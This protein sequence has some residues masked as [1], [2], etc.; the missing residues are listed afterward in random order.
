MDKIQIKVL[1]VEDNPVDIV[2]LRETLG[3][4]A[5]NSFELTA[6]ERLQA[7]AETLS[8]NN[9]DVILLDLGLPDSQGLETFTHL[10][11]FARE[12]P[13]IILSGLTDESLA[14][15]AVHHGAQDYLVK[16]TTG[17]VSAARAIRYAIERQKAQAAV[18]ASEERFR[19]MIENGLDD[20]SLLDANGTLLWESPSVIRSLGYPVDTFV[21]KNIFEIVHPEDQGWTG[22]LYAKVLQAPGSREAGIFRLRHADGSW[23]WIEAIVTNM[24]NNPSVQAVV[25]NYR[26]ITE[27]KQAEETVR[28]LARFPEENPSPILRVEKEGRILYANSAAREQW[29]AGWELSVNDQ[30]P[31]EWRARA[32]DVF[33]TN[34][35]GSSDISIQERIYEITIAPFQESGYVNI[36]GRDITERKRA[37]AALRS[38]ETRYRG[39]FDGVQ[40]AIFVEDLDGNILDVNRRA[41]EIFG[42]THAE[43]IAKHVKDIV[44]AEEHMIRLWED[45]N[46]SLE[47]SYETVNVRA[48]GEQFP[49]EIRGGFYEF[50]DRKLFLVVLRDITERKQGEEK[51]RKSE[52]RHRTLVN[53]IPDMMFRITRAGV[54]LD[55]NGPNSQPY[56]APE[57]FLGKKITE[58]MPPAI[59]AQC[60][61]ALAASFEVGPQT[62]EYQLSMGGRNVSYEARAVSNP[63][64]D[65]A[66]F[67]VRDITERKQMEAS[68]RA[69]EERYR[70]LVENM[71]DII[72]E[73]DAQGKLCYI[74]PNYETE[75]GYCIADELG[76]LAFT[77]VHPDD[78][79]LFLQ[80]AKKVMGP[81][82][83][84]SMVYRVQNKSGKWRWLETS[85]KPYQTADGSFHI[86][87]VARDI[88]ERKQAEVELK[89][90]TDDLKLINTINN[91]VVQGVSLHAIMD[92]LAKGL[93]QVFDIEGTSVYLLDPDGKSLAMQ[94][95]IISPELTRSIEKV[96]GSTVPLIHIPIQ[97]GGYFEKFI[98][99]GRGTIM[100]DPDATQQWMAEF[101]ETSFLPSVARNAV[102]KLIPQI[103]K[104]MHIQSTL[105]AP[106]IS[107]GQTIGMLDASSVTRLF[108]NEDL[109]RIENICGQLTAAIQRQQ[110]NASIERSEAFLN[111][112]QNALSA[113]LAILD[114]KGTIVRV[115]A[116]WRKFGEQNGLKNPNACVGVNYLE[117]CDK[118][119]G[120]YAEEA[121]ATADAIRA[122]LTGHRK[123]MLLEYPCHG[124]QEQRWFTLR[125]T[126]FEDGEHAWVVLAHENITERKLAEQQTLETE[127]RFRAL[128]ERAPDGI[129]LVSG[130]G[131]YKYASPTALRLFDYTPEEIFAASPNAS[132]H[133]DDL[134]AVLGSLQDLIE[135]PS[136][137]ATL[138]YR[139]RHKDGTWRWLE[140][141]FTNMLAEPGVEAIV[142]NFRDITDR[143]QAEEAT[144]ETSEQF[145]TLFEASPEA[146]MLVDPNNS[147]WTIMDCN[148]TGC[149]MNGYTH[150]ELIGQS[151]DILNP[152][153]GDPA[154]RMDY[155]ARIRTAGILR[156]EASHRRKDGTVFPIEVATSLIRLGGREVI[157]GI[158]RDITER[159][160]AEEALHKSEALYRQAIE[161][162]GAVP[163]YESYYDNGQ[164]IKYDFIG[165]G[166]RQITGY[167]PEEFNAQVWDSLVEEA[168]LVDDLQGY[169]ID[170]GI[171]R[172]RAGENPIWK[173]E[174]RIR[175]RAGNLHWVFEAAVEL[176]DASG[177]SHGSIGT[178]QDITARKQAE[179]SLRESEQRYRA[180]FEDMPV[181]IWEEDFSEVKKYSDSLK[182]QGIT[183]FR[184]YFEANPE[185]A[186]ECAPKV[187]ILNANRAAVE[188]FH[189][190][191]KAELLSDTEQELSQGEKA[192]FV[193][194]VTN[195]AEG[196]T[197]NQ[198]EGA[199]E[200]YTGV[201][202]EINLNWSVVPGYEKDY[203]RIIVTTVDITE[204]KRAEREL[205]SSHSL[206]TATF[207]STADGIL[208]VGEKGEIISFNRR[209]LEL[210]HIPHE[211]AE[212][213]VDRPLLEF[214][215]SQL[216]DPA[217]F[218][219]KVEELYHAP[220]ETSIDE[221]EFLDGRVFERYSQPQRLGNTIIGRVWSFR[222]IT[223][224]KRAYE[225]VRESEARFASIF[226]ANP[227]RVSIT[228]FADGRFLDVNE[229]FLNSTGLNREEVIGRTSLEF[230]DWVDPQERIRLRTLLQEQGRVQHFET[231]LR[232]K[233]GEV[234]DV[235]ISAELVELFGQ[236]CILSV[237]LDI[238]DRKQ[239]EQ[240]LF[241]A[242][243]RFTQL[244]DNIQEVFWITDAITGEDLYISPAGEKIWGHSLADLMQIPDIFINTI[245]PEDRPMVL[246][247]I[248]GQKKGIATEIEYRIV[249]P[250][251]SIHW[252]WDRAFPI[253]DE[254]GN[255]LRVAGIAVDITERKQVDDALRARD[256]LLQDVQK[257]ARLGHYQLDIPSG[258]WES[259]DVLNDVLGIDNDYLKDMNGWVGLIHP[260][261][262]A[263]MLVY[264]NTEV[265]EEHKPFDRE[266]QMVRKDNGQIRWVHGLGQL[267]FDNTGNPV[268]M[269]GTIQ[270]ITERKQIEAETRRHLAELEA[271]YE[272]GLA[273]GR[274]LEPREIGERIIATFAR[275]LSWHHV[276]IRLIE[277]ESLE[278]ELIAFN[279][280]GMND[281]ANQDAQRNLNTLISKV[282]Q[283]LSGWVAQTGQP[284]RTGNVNAQPHYIATYREINSGLYMPLKI[285]ERCIG[286][287]SV[288]SHEPDAFSEQDERLL[289]TLASQAANAFENARLYEVVQQEL[290]ERTR[291]EIALRTSETHYRELTDSITDVF[292]EMDQNLCYTHWNKASEKL[293][294]IPEVSALGRSMHEVMGVSEEQTRIEKIYESV[295][296]SQH[297]T[298]FETHLSFNNQISAHE[299]TAYP[300]TRGVAV[301]AKDVSER[302]RSEII[303]QKRFELMEYAARHTLLETMQR[304]VDEV[305]DLTGSHIGFF[306]ILAA[307]QTTPGLQIW[308]TKTL[309][310]FNIPVSEGE[311]Q[312]VEQAGVWAEA[313]RQRRAIIH[314]DYE[315]MPNKKGLPTGHA[316]LIREIVIPVIRNETILAVLGIGNK[317]EEYTQ[318]DLEIAERFTD[319]AWDITERKQMELALSEERNQLALRV[320]ERTADFSRANANLAR[321]LRV[322]DEFLANM[323][324]ELRTPLNAIL[325][326]SE[327]L[328]EQTAGPLNEKQ[329]RYI[330][331][332]TESGHHLLS[333]I[334][335]ILDLAKIEAGQIT[336]DVNKVDIHSVCEASLRMIKQLA[337]KK[338]Q[339]TFL[340]IDKNIGLMWAD[341]RRLKQML[342]NLLSNAVKFT[343]NDGKLGLEVHGDR[344]AN[345]VTFTI[346]DTGIGIKEADLL[347]LFQPFVQL[348]AG[349]ARESSGT[350][351]GL[352]LVAQMARLHG[353]GTSV[354]SEPGKGSRF[355]IMLPWEQVLVLDAVEKL[356]ITGK[357]RPIKFSKERKP[358]ILLIE[359]TEDVIMMLSDYLEL[360]GFKVVTARDGIEGV[361]QAQ[362]THPDLILMDIQMPRM[363]GFEATQKLRSEPD[364]KKTPIIALTALAMPNDRE[365]C[366]AAGMDE[367]ITKPVHLRALVKLIENFL[368]GDQEVRP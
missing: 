235:L 292:F 365:R 148:A 270:D 320:E 253:S 37:E 60:M 306:H 91:A 5:L 236:R 350:G 335:D 28:S 317:P 177:V 242:N 213:R 61:T 62:F 196:K 94:Q 329:M 38:S 105:I 185:A 182:A 328:A 88:T 122:V 43:F 50:G 315:S 310:L 288:E 228:S 152:T 281:E 256:A 144:R 100:N 332:V 191:S 250:D 163:Y 80:K 214:V 248:E 128:I 90:R 173:C 102:R 11:Q 124:P 364:F 194:F 114:E 46:I 156:Y 255:V 219:A 362:L 212:Q 8:E 64:T 183:D 113:N 20:I 251:G 210:W 192:H 45:E 358:S 217:A 351:L 226:N 201:P 311:H 316:P 336:L 32:T 237:G 165:E 110:A 160:Q 2:L 106:L 359:D 81:A 158:D 361:A 171:Q 85:G 347:R 239:N 337:R 119:T 92:L 13:K 6:V 265:V 287:I 79:P 333:L 67:I 146:I 246:L 273:V 216:K 49:V 95:F 262:Q 129:V 154:G 302:K 313:V 30:L 187:K 136:K 343:P 157:L 132:T 25:V 206:L 178:Y 172:V 103:Y 197:G 345:K 199:D 366:L 180:L 96:L 195:I 240:K 89:Q 340:E 52:S 75:S 352:A 285:G 51:L 344:E 55:F 73:V 166:I 141:T 204:R 304:T 282:G 224:R 19:A 295:L 211:L 130:A 142:I 312:A 121:H 245:L 181:A 323:S 318:Q 31:E 324:H 208:V 319:Y 276:A 355:T 179:N 354:V 266:Y 161:V 97:A 249:H 260:N 16:G 109:Q 147:D 41:C 264:F 143:K 14:L 230:D 112:V 309:S 115:N 223:E 69:N 9:F 39:I 271:L 68:L 202:L 134:P 229:A 339:E 59:A 137:T 363:D 314:N 53:A 357:F 23:R 169:T 277:P 341:E 21:G 65:E 120:Q 140:S 286:V 303:L 269:I 203:S 327:S 227:T 58:I 168:S 205:I 125:I 289:A 145:R 162:A 349:L 193:E 257:I 174:H 308:S 3:Q 104:L 15:Q 44:P 127:K 133:P 159:K 291:A 198:W 283:G 118:A 307:D 297:P 252:I 47:H 48:N 280:V 117:V 36:Y 139:F 18:R 218:I 83:S 27:R 86:I 155:L 107:N 24:V 4:D 263:E 57:A 348:D 305:V 17:F 93:K 63:S 176:R 325:G 77:H 12:I 82:E 10:H 34:T 225:Q 233:S 1:L 207:E 33:Q 334:N 175:D 238:T 71:T 126:K 331:T 367:Y 254:A 278:M 150:D 149:A 272:N 42:Y 234:L 101:V 70:N 232:K 84:Q 98:Q 123:D 274:L 267:E 40:D 243:E 56:V 342:V 76:T 111:S 299:V 298:T 293:T 66:V 247:T 338:N 54:Y 78:L 29:L 116:A 290:D 275:Y 151:V 209:F 188:M 368:V 326:L 346:W 186:F 138:Q 321:A 153:P 220:E 200:T 322:K 356:K 244:A 330:T 221:L 189:G 215:L 135:H 190:A 108:T 268:R 74:S 167:G 99:A 164:R 360:N 35:K 72:L 87:S 261:Q 301:V 7:A 279:Q 296:L 26:D 131:Q 294:G 258:V 353:G 22:D 222:E 241:E 284:L 259:S 184:A 231:R 300:S 170:E